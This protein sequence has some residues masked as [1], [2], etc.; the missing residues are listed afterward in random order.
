MDSD[1]SQNQGLVVHVAMLGA[2]LHYA[3]PRLLDQAGVLGTFYTDAYLGNKQRIRR[4][5][6]LIPSKVKPSS[7][8]R[9]QGRDC[10][11]LS[12]SR[13]VS[14]DELG[15]L[16][17]WLRKRRSSRSNHN[18]I[19]VRIARA[20]GERVVRTGLSRGSA[21]YG[22]NGAAL[23]IFREAKRCG[24]RCI[25]EQTIAPYRIL[26]KLLKEEAEFWPAWESDMISKSAA[27]VLAEREEAEWA[28]ADRIIC[29]S[30]F[31]EEG[32]K[33]LTVE[34][35]KCRVVPYG[36]DV[37]HFRP[38]ATNVNKPGLNILFVGEVG[39]RKGVPYLLHALRELDSDHL[40]CRLVG[41]VSLDR[42]KLTDF[43][44]WVEI[45]GPVP[46]SQIREMYNWADI[47]VFPSICE[48]SA[49]VTYEA[50]ACGL[51]IITTPNSGSVAR[52]GEEGFIV[53]IRKAAAIAERIDQFASSGNLLREMSYNARKRIEQFSWENYSARL[54]E[55]IGPATLNSP[56]FENPVGMGLSDRLNSPQNEILL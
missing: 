48:G 17:Y 15:L 18:A 52:D 16:S 36:I 6:E 45:F 38:H 30:T 46:R 24:L 13:V 19:Q 35:E 21:V 31:V 25:L 12:R 3:V 10:T 47:L 32:L 33:L 53:P 44:R 51:P 20:F 40:R 42:K 23:E 22:F 1:L 56:A 29:G 39:L 34:T 14:Y 41:A 7:V 49:F 37:S 43:R 5:L 55:V 26:M 8:K 9:L 50:M 4:L 28:L 11:G 54:M 27:E 2:R